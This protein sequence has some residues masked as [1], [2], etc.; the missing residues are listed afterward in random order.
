MLSNLAIF[1][2]FIILVVAVSLAVIAKKTGQPLI[3]AYILTGVVLGPIFFNFISQS[4]IIHFMEELG[5]A[6]LLF[7]VGT[8]MKFGPLRKIIKSVTK[9]SFS[10]IIIQQVLAFVVAYLLGFGLMEALIVSVCTIFGA[11]PVVVKL[12]SDKDELGSEAGRIDVGTLIIQDIYLIIV[13]AIMRLDDF[14]D[15]SSVAFGLLEVFFLII[16]IGVV[17]YFISTKLVKKWL[18]ETSQTS[19]FF[20]I[21]ITWLFVFLSLSNYLDLSLEIGAFLAGLGLGQIPFGEEVREKIRPLTNFFMAV[22]FASLGL[23]LD[24]DSVLAY[25][26]EALIAGVVLTLSNFFVLYYLVKWQGFG[27]ETSFKSSVNMMQLSE[28]SLVIGGIALVTFDFFTDQA[29]GYLTIMTIVTILVSAYLIK[30]NHTLYLKLKDY[31]PGEDSKPEG[32]ILEN[33]VVVLGYQPW[34]LQAVKECK[35]DVVI[36]A[37]DRRVLDLNVRY[38][39]GNPSHQALRD[40]VNMSRA[41]VVIN[42]I[43]DLELNRN[44]R[45]ETNAK[46][47]V[48]T[49]TNMFEQYKKEGFENVFDENKLEE[50]HVY[51]RLKRHLL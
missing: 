35:K 27:K 51:S 32:D 22:F 29:L 15:I 14:S 36:L 47:L 38:E 48:R 20:L 3:V 25:W 50:E 23:V 34:I 13:I 5:L 40:E 33:H 46:M 19:V 9:I 28:F 43:D 30:Y 8:E 1:E 2:L 18:N 45:D 12:L 41:K 21:S 37:E 17:S 10:Q 4:E 24:L 11:T 7:L 44:I 39:Y 6:F 42:L 16:V 26:K 31:L 49:K